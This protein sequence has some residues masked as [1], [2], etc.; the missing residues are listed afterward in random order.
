MKPRHQYRHNTL[1]LTLPAVLWLSGTQGIHAQTNRYWDPS[2]SGNFGS[3]GATPTWTSPLNL[4]WTNDSTGGSTRLANYTTTLTDIC[5]WGGPTAALGGG[6]VPVGTVNAGSLSFNTISGSGTVTL[7]GGTITLASATS[8]NALTSTQTHTISS[9][10]A[11][12]ATSMTKTGLGTIVLSGSNTY[13]GS[14]II[15][16]GTLTLGNANALA[17]SPLDTATSIAGTASSGLKATVAS[18]TFGGISGNKDLASVFT[19]TSGGF[20]SLSSLTLNPANAVIT[21]YSGIISD[22]AV[23]MTLTKNGA[24]TQVLQGANSYTGATTVNAGTL[25]LDYS[26]QDNNKLS[27][28]GALV[29]GNGTINLAGGTGCMTKIFH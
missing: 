25:T 1:L 26:T 2:G 10:L 27:D 7:S 8:I 6:T 5:N 21:T 22:G 24:G 15:S 4:I 13:A 18:L 9:T 28:T 12:A 23:G 29:L 3:I 20:G 16:A 19:T 14:T 17:N 11:G